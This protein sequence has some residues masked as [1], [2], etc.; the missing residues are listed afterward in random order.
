MNYTIMK[1]L[2]FLLLAIIS[3]SAYGQESSYDMRYV[4]AIRVDAKDRV[5]RKISKSGD[6]III[7]KYYLEESKDLVVHIDKVENKK[8]GKEIK[9]WYYCS[10][11][12]NKYIIV[13]LF[14]PIIDF[15]KIVS[16][17][18]IEKRNVSYL[19]L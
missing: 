11:D 1:K 4:R 14:G 15:Y 2:L 16:E 3:L 7:E 13:G 6:F 10:D 8:H 19:G 9:D 12:K 17:V 18:D 5:V